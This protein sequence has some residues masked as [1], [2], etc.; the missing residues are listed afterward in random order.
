MQTIS[1]HLDQGHDPVSA[2]ALPRVHPE[3]LTTESGERRTYGDK[4]NLEMTPERGWAPEI[5][6][7]LEEAG[8]EVLPIEAHASFGRVHLIAASDGGW[9]GVAD[10]DWEGTW[11]GASCASR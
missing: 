3:R 8:F 5:A 11:A 2:V 9:L 4:V 6:G 7:Q 10:P 1:R